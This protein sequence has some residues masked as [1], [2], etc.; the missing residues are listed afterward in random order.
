MRIFGFTTHGGPEVASLLHASKPTPG[1]GQVLIEVLASSVNPGDIKTREG[2]NEFEVIFPMAF[3]REAAGRVIALGHG[4]EGIE[5]DELVFGSAASGY[6]C[7]ADYTLLDAAA[8]AA[9]PEGL[10]LFQAACIPVAYGTAYDALDQLGLHAGQSLVVVGA[11]G[12]VGTAIT[13]LAVARGIDVIGVASAGKRELISSLGGRPVASGDGWVE[14]VLDIAE[15]PAAVFDVVG[16]TVLQEA[17]SLSDA[18]ISVADRSLVVELGGTG[19]E[20]RRD[21][22]TYVKLAQ[23]LTDGRAQ[24]TIGEVLPLERAAE[25]VSL[26]EQGHATAKVVVRL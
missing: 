24:V 7:F 6:G 20:R 11:G 21:R 13:A 1:P 16:G 26:V 17:S 22:E 23:L 18:L 14:R 9:V 10:P 15:H 3:G 8:T 12:G 4:V 2:T 19:V 5:I 25:A